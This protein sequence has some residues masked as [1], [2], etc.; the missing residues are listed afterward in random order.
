MRAAMTKVAALAQGVR[1]LVSAPM[2]KG[3]TKSTT[4]VRSSSLRQ[5][6]ADA[7]TGYGYA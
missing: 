2:G 5:L 1:V 7:V 4:V 3:A 6:A